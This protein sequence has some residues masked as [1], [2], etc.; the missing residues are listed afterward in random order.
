MTQ[1]NPQ[2]DSPPQ[3][4]DMEED[5]LHNTVD[6]TQEYPMVTL[7]NQMETNEETHD[8]NYIQAPKMQPPTKHL[9]KRKREADHS[10]GTTKGTTSPIAEISLTVGKTGTEVGAA[11]GTCHGIGSKTEVGAEIGTR[12]GAGTI[13]IGETTWKRDPAQDPPLARIPH[14]LVHR[15]PHYLLKTKLLAHQPQKTRTLC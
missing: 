4:I 2:I 5:L 7:D 9:T 8:L 12:I 3:A 11:T 10:I 14:S 13:G 1:E 6:L 15:P